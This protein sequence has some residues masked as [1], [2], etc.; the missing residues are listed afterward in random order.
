MSFWRGTT[1]EAAEPPDGKHDQLPLLLTTETNLSSPKDPD[2]FASGISL[3]SF[4]H[5]PFSQYFQKVYAFAFGI[6]V[7]IRFIPPPLYRQQAAK[8]ALHFPLP[9]S[10]QR[11]FPIPVS[12]FDTQSNEILVY[13]PPP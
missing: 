8:R 9:L 6:P 1:S 13:C 10:Q 11:P 5:I 4:L 2:F 12:H 7:W 3:L